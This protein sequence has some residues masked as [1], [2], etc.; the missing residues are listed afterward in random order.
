[1]APPGA[2]HG[3]VWVA[4]AGARLRRRCGRRSLFRSP[5]RN[6]GGAWRTPSSARR[7]IPQQGGAP[8][9]GRTQGLHEIWIED[10]VAGA[11]D[12]L[13]TGGTGSTPTQEDIDGTRCPPR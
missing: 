11:K 12:L 5:A 13:E 1:M 9:I 6:G 4:A 8:A 2:Y 10:R 3:Q 7:S